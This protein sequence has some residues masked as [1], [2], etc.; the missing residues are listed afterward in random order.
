LQ[1]EISIAS[2]II[3]ILSEILFGMVI[4][5]GLQLAYNV[6]TYA[7]GIISFMMG[8]SM[9][10]AIDPQNGVSMPIVS[11]F[12]S[13]LGLMILFALD[14][15]H[16]LII[17]IYQSLQFIPLGGFL[18]TNNMNHL[19]CHSHNCCIDLHQ[20]YKHYEK[21]KDHYHSQ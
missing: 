14:L 19:R 1:I 12:L 8:F 10:T 3:A 9:A 17:Y 13:L 21:L 4:G 2:I 7:G 16:W 15:H 5:I 11:Q 18:I 20:S 6:I